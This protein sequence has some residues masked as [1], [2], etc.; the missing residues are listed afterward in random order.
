[1]SVISEPIGFT[2]ILLCDCYRQIGFILVVLD[3][4]GSFANDLEHNRR[5]VLLTACNVFVHNVYMY[6]TFIMV[7]F[8]F[9]VMYIQYFNHL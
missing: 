4:I 3:V 9:Y 6:F 1:V 7:Y 2:S 5:V 8:W